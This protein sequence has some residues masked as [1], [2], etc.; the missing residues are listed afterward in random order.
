MCRPDPSEQQLLWQS[1]SPAPPVRPSTIR[2][3]R[4]ESRIH[5][6]GRLMQ[7]QFTLKK[8]RILLASAGTSS[9][10]STTANDKDEP[11]LSLHKFRDESRNCDSTFVTPAGLIVTVEEV[12]GAFDA[13]ET[14]AVFVR[15]SCI[16]KCFLLFVPF[17]APVFHNNF[18]PLIQCILLTNHQFTSM[19]VSRSHTTSRNT[20]TQ[21]DALQM[22]QPDSA[23]WVYLM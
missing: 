18:E 13:P 19:D 2:H 20:E 6:E 7:L 9:R 10:S 12:W 23:H 4:H 21:W 5:H 14:P 17:K 15:I 11:L 1:S 16:S 8:L 22:F 3:K